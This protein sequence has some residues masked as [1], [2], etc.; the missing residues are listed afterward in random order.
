MKDFSYE[1]SLLG[2]IP[3]FMSN[4][5]HTLQIQIWPH[6]NFSHCST[7]CSDV[8]MLACYVVVCSC[9]QMFSV[10]VLWVIVTF[11]WCWSLTA[12]FLLQ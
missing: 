5:I 9:I 12:V 4:L 8:F 6:R 2:C 10:Y 3:H 7:N 11:S 1:N